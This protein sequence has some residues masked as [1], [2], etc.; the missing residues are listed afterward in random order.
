MKN[1][2]VVFI[3]ASRFGCCRGFLFHKHRGFLRYQSEVKN[4]LFFFL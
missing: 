1:I 4:F 2:Q 3:A